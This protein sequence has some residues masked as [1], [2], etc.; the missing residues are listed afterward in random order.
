MVED[1]SEP[2]VGFVCFAGVSF[3]SGDVVAWA[4]TRPRREMLGRGEPGHVDTDLGDDTFGGPFP[5]PGNR[6][7]PVAGLNERGHHPVDFT[8]EFRDR[9]LEMRG[10]VQTQSD[11]QGVVFTETA[12]ERLA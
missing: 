11:H 2:H 8:V 9:G 5:D 3:A 1:V 10:V 6:V 4:D 7:E 12:V